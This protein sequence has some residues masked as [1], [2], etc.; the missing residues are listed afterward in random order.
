MKYF[1]KILYKYRE[2]NRLMAT[3]SSFLEKDFLKKDEYNTT[4]PF[5]YY[6]NIIYYEKYGYFF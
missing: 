5:L 3:C 4:I 2:I 6:N 1:F